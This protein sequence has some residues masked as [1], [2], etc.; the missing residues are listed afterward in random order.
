MRSFL[1]LAVVACSGR[2]PPPAAKPKPPDEAAIKKMSADVLLAYDRADAAATEYALAN[3]FVQF[4]GGEPTTRDKA[5]ESIKKR[6][7]GTPMFAS[8]TWEH[9]KVLVHPDYIL[10]VGKATE[11]QG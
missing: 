5:L 11:T 10:F 2:T 6:K 8:R 4:E 9:E 7:P 1:V 3:D